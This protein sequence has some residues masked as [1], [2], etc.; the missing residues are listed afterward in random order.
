M[1][2]L[3]QVLRQELERKR[4]REHDREQYMRN[5]ALAAGLAEEFIDPEF[6]PVTRIQPTAK[7][8]QV[9]ANLPEDIREHLDGL[10][11]TY[12]NLFDVKEKEMLKKKAQPAN[13]TKITL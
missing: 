4:Q 2:S 7:A 12:D 5:S 10:L 3:N 6:P 11:W 1:T 13:Q 9:L 8:E